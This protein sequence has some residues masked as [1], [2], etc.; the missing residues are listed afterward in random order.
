MKDNLT[1]VNPASFLSAQS[2]TRSRSSEMIIMQVFRLVIGQWSPRIY[3]HWLIMPNVTSLITN[4][5]GGIGV[6]Y[7][8]SI[9]IHNVTFWLIRT[10]PWCI[11]SP[12]V[13]Y[14]Y[15]YI[16]RNTMS[17]FSNIK[18]KKCLFQ[19]ISVLCTTVHVQTKRFY[20]AFSIFIYLAKA[21]TSS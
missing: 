16:K 17:S 3:S 7:Q 11:Q 19:K 5:E 9:K 20:T 12:R 13:N 4:Q 10:Y 2:V 14:K 8:G 15:F 18:L 1:Q 6:R 21:L